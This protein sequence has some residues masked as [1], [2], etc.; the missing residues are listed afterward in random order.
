MDNQAKFY[1]KLLFIIIAFTTICISGIDARELE[2]FEP[3]RLFNVPVADTLKSFDLNASGA[4][5]FGT[6]Q[7]SFLGTGY[8]GL[9]HIAQ[10]EIS[11]VKI[12][13]KLDESETELIGIPAAGIKISIPGERTSWILPNISASYRRTFNRSEKSDSIAYQREFADLYVIASKTIISLKGWRGIRLH[14]GV[15]YIGASF[16]GSKMPRETLEKFLPFGG[17]EIWATRKTKLMGEFEWVA[18]FAEQN[19]PKL[20]DEPVWMAI[21]GARIFLTRFLTTDVGV[22]YQENF[23]TI[24]DAKIEAR[25]SITIPTHLIYEF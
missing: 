21:V 6:N 25:V 13:R 23:K 17:I 18:N 20:A 12:L 15:D 3:P 22:R 19:T 11:P 16:T 4:G 5:A 24:A 14:G 1:T 10:V 9:G 7:F 8:L 2:L